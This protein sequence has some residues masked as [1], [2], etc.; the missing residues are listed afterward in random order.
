[1]GMSSSQARLLTLTSRLHDIEISAQQL[2]S[3]KLSL[4]TQQDRLY[5]DYCDS[6]D[7][8]KI[9]VAFD[10]GL[11]RTYVDAN[12]N[13]VCHYNED[14][15]RQYA[16]RDSVSGK[17]VVDGKVGQMYDRYSMDKYS[18]AWAMMGMDEQF[19]WDCDEEDNDGMRIGFRHSPDSYDFDDEEEGLAMTQVESLVFEK[20]CSDDDKLQALYEEYESAEGLEK[21]DK[22]TAFRDALYSNSNFKAHIYDYM[23]LDK[24][25]DYKEDEEG[26]PTCEI[27]DTFE[28]TFN[29]D[30]FNYYVHLFEEIQQNGGYI[31]LDKLS[32]SSV[33]DN[34][35]FNS[36]VKSGRVLI[37]VYNPTGK[38]G[39]TETSI[40][41]SSNE[42]Y[43][44]E[45][46]NKDN[47]KKVEAEYQ[48]QLKILDKKDTQIDKDL[49]KLE[50]ERNAI[51]KEMDSI[52]QVKDDNIER[53]FGLFS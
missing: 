38:K 29:T 6:L 20:Y 24:Y 13:N 19:N 1:M 52:K 14:R 49:S 7:A 45:I 40:A 12:F 2:E 15:V 21:N 51:T 5:Q 44:Q 34:D 41:T 4:A 48:R 32:G 36:M 22:L 8:K 17:V 39:W 50:T 3:Q 9:Q 27:D 18:F 42:N 11:S 35:W 33:A 53:T 28:E 23:R 37:D 25:E 16:L 47:L 31:E 43:L 46:Q 30:E 10:G 26:N